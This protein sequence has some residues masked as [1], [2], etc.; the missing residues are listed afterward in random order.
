MFCRIYWPDSIKIFTLP[1]KVGVA[2]IVVVLLRKIPTAVV[3]QQSHEII[4]SVSPV[5]F[6]C[7]LHQ[8]EI[9]PSIDRYLS[10]ELSDQ[11]ATGAR[12]RQ[13]ETL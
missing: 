10:S 2:A 7:R 8:G 6:S 9:Q 1:R 3:G 13:T 5:F 11:A 4:L 12:K